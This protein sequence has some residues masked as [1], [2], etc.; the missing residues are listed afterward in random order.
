MKY[1][2]LIYSP[3]SAQDYANPAESQIKDVTDYVRAVKD[4]GVLVDAQQ[5]THTDSATTVRV[6]GGDRL[7]SDGPFM[8]TKE[9]LLGFFLLD[10]PDLDTALDWA[11]RMPAACFGTVEVRAVQAGR[12]WQAVLEED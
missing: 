2:L 10:V 9:H 7:V 5:L 11:A 3:T 12:P 6:R 4:A 1:A 8:E